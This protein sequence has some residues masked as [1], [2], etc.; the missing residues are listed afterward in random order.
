MDSLNKVNQTNH[1]IL[2]D[3]SLSELQK[4]I[5]TNETTLYISY[6]E[7]DSATY[8]I[9]IDQKGAQVKKINH[10]ENYKQSVQNFLQTISQ[11]IET[12]S[13]EKQFLNA[14]HPLYQI[15]LPTDIASYPEII[16]NPSGVLNAIAFDALS[17]NTTRSGLMIHDH[18][19]RYTLSPSIELMANT[20]AASHK[21]NFL[22][23]APVNFQHIQQQDL[24]NS[25]IEVK[26]L[27]KITKG[28]LL[29]HANAKKSA[30]QEM[31]GSYQ[32]I[33]LAT[34]SMAN[35]EATEF[36]WIAFSDGKMHLPEIY[37]LPLQD[38]FVVLSACETYR[39]EVLAGEGV[40]NLVWAL[41]YAGSKSMVATLWNTYDRA[42]N[43]I[44]NA[45][46]THLKA[47]VSKPEALRNAK[48]KYIHENG[49]KPNQWASFIY[50][51]EAN[52]LEISKNKT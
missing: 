42:S 33:H 45:F 15:L 16:I 14:A 49:F 17:K 7:G 41:H 3:I 27:R 24:P 31:V 38:K 6:L 26:Q 11:P 8:A 2:R 37:N 51:G 35:A 5:T 21:N 48:L 34:H 32:N 29:I 4:K 10:D 52:T 36:P 30:F 12:V 23:F 1:L 22:Y 39:G 47:G 9:F 25:A 46:Y 20:I 13:Q 43:E 19:I 50:I 18:I 28:K 44:M 40:M